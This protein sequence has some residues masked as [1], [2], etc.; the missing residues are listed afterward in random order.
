MK[1]KNKRIAFK[2]QK[3]KTAVFYLKNTLY[4]FHE[5]GTVEIFHSYTIKFVF[6]T[7]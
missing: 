7:F 3:K 5:F 1:T 4:F 2:E 6:K